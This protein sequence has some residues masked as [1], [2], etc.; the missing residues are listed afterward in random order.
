[1]TRF[2]IKMATYKKPGLRTWETIR[3]FDN[4]KDADEWLCSF[5]RSN[6]YSITDFT[7]KRV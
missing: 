7:I 5:C 6:N 1:M 4:P 3:T 2:E